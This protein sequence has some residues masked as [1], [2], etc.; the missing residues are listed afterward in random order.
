MPISRKVTSW[1]AVALLASLSLAACSDTGDRVEGGVGPTT[2]ANS[3]EL[4]MANFNA[5]M[6]A[7]SQKAGTNHIEMV[8]TAAGQRVTASGDQKLG[9]TLEDNAASMTMDYG[10]AGLGTAK[11]VVVDGQFYMNFGRLTGN[12][13]GKADLSDPSDPFTQQLAPIIEQMDISRQIE[14]L[15]TALKSV[16]KTGDPKK[17]DGVETQPYKVVVDTSEIDAFDVLPPEAKRMIPK[18]LTYTMFVGADGLMRRM[19]YGFSGMTGTLNASKWGEPVDIKA[20][21][22]DEVSDKDL[23]TLL[24]LSSEI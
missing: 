9:K 10:D 6:V 23:A 2:T 20:P 4:T 19:T 7:A 14:E 5:T 18:T 3:T 16:E 24:R 15:S 12:K 21:S 1:A 22:A 17:I 11:V 13:F 8:I